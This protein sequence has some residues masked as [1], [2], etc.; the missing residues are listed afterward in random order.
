[1]AASPRDLLQLP[2]AYQAPD[3]ALAAPEALAGLRVAQDVTRGVD[4]APLSQLEQL[5]H[6][7]GKLL[8]LAG[9]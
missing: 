7:V 1:M 5:T 6:L 9:L 3:L 2:V 8:D 4:G